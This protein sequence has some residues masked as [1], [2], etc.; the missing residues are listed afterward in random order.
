[1]AAIERVLTVFL[2]GGGASVAADMSIS[3][4]VVID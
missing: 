3:P 2:A 4:E 1:M